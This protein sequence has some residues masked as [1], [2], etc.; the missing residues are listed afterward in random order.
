M[1]ITYRPSSE[2]TGELEFPLPLWFPLFSTLTSDVVLLCTFQTKTSRARLK[3][4]VTRSSAALQNTTHLLSALIIPLAE[5]PVPPA[6]DCNDAEG[7]E[8]ATGC[9]R[10]ETML[11][12]PTNGTTMGIQLMCRLC[13]KPLSLPA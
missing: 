3:S 13:R 5:S 1:N 6:A 7:V 8:M 10:D 9:A 2:I 12:I 11:S 4:F